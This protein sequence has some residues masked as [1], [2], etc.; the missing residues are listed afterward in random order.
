[1]VQLT[2]KAF[3][4]PNHLVGWNSFP[5]S[6]IF[7]RL[8]PF[9]NFEEKDKMYLS[10]MVQLT[11]RAFLCPNHLV[12]W[13]SFPCPRCCWWHQSQS[14]RCTFASHVSSQTCP[15]TVQE[16]IWKCQN[17]KMSKSEKVKIWKYQNLK[18]SKS[19]NVKI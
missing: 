13:N 4:C 8:S 9:T 17:L 11:M 16:T 10:R 3:L 6:I 14:F 7:L 19:E 12:E 15:S 2:M 5:C 1:M 18:M